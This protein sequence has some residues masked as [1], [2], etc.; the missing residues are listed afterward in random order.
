MQTKLQKMVFAAL[1]A[2]LLAVL[3]PFVIPVGLVPITLATFVV[4][5]TGALLPPL[6]A[7]ASIGVYLLIG[8]VGLPVFSGF[9]GGPGVLFGPTGGFLI[10][11]FCLAGAVSLAVKLSQKWWVWAIGVLLGMVGLY[12]FGAV[13]FILM[14]K[15]DLI[16]ALS[17]CVAPFVLPDLIKAGL[18]LTLGAVLRARLGARVRRT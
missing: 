6:Y 16:A 17:A 15:A 12:L 10:G 1:L 13:W 7:V 5:L 2:A 14:M 4:F 3:S 8:L 9:V 18:A 11:Y